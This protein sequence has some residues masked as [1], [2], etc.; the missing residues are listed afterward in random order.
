MR[1]RDRGRPAGRALDVDMGVMR[2]GAR[3]RRAG[4]ERREPVARRRT[5][6]TLDRDADLDGIGKG[7]AGEEPAAVFDDD[8]DRRAADGIEQTRLDE[9][10]VHRRVEEGV[11]GDVVEMAIGVV[12]VPAARDRNEADEGGARRRFGA[13][14]RLGRAAQPT[15]RVR[16][17][18]RAASASAAASSVLA[19]VAAQKGATPTAQD[20]AAPR[21]KP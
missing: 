7:Q 16:L 4:L 3:E 6:E 14:R 5:P 15:L 18:R 10:P 8:A 13:R 12:V 2:L 17:K 21:C 1:L 11:I 9:D 19:I 20:L